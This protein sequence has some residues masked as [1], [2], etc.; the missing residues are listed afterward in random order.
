MTKIILH[1]FLDTLYIYLKAITVLT[2]ITSTFVVCLTG[3]F[4]GVTLQVKFVKIWKQ[5]FYMMYT[6]FVHL[7]HD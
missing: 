5:D 6:L 7:S 3:H 2:T 1:S 4:L